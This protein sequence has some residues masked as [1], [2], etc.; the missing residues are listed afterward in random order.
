MKK[1]SSGSSHKK[2]WTNMSIVCVSPPSRKYYSSGNIPLQQM[3]LGNQLPFCNN[4]LISR[5]E[6]KVVFKGEDMLGT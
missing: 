5:L 3:P 2:F 4:F 1:A 6:D